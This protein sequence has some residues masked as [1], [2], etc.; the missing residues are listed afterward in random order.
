M[1]A[2]GGGEGGVDVEVGEHLFACRGDWKKKSMELYSMLF[3]ISEFI[4]ISSQDVQATSCK[5]FR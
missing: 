4:S 2:P 1:K 3:R 5:R